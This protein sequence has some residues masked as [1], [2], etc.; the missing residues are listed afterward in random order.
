LSSEEVKTV[1][2]GKY[3]SM[4]LRGR[5]EFVQRKNISGIVGIVPI[6]DSNELVLVDQYRAAVGKRVFELPAGLA[7]DIAGQEDESFKTAADRE[8]LEETGSVRP[9]WENPLSLNIQESH[10]PHGR[11]FKSGS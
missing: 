11:P 8:L 1:W 4:K 7:G 9:A 3:L 6:T 2:D 5:W 10:F